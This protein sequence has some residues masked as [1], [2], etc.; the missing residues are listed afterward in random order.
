MDHLDPAETRANATWK[1]AVVYQVYPWTFAEDSQRSPQLGH[2]SIKGI[3]ERLPYLES[4]GVNALWLSPFYPSPMVDG[5]YDVADFKN[6]HPLLGTLD[7][8]DSLIRVAHEKHIRLMV[9]FVANHT[10]DQHEWF[11]KSRRREG[12]YDDWY[13]WRPGTV[14]EHGNRRPPNNWASVFSIPQRKARER[15]EMSWL[16]PEE[17]TPPVSAWKWDEVREEFY[18]HSFAV[19]QP[20]LNWS[21]SQVREA[22]K[23]IMRFWL[24]RGVDG[25]R[26]DAINHVGKNMELHDEGVNTAYNE[27][28]YENPYDQLL[29]HNSCNYPRTLHDYIWQMCQVLKEEQYKD[30]DLRAVLEAYM[31]ESELR[32]MDAIA[33][34][35][36]STFNF[37]GLLASWDAGNRKI[38]MD[39]YYERLQRDAVANQVN[40]NHDKPRLASRLG[41]NGA[42]A[43]AVLNL[44]LPGMRFVYSGEEL[45]LVDA[46]VPAWRMQDP[47]GLRD[48]ERTPIPW[49]D[50]LPNAGFST[51]EPGDLWLPTNAA[52]EHK[53]V[54]RQKQQ[55]TSSLAL[56]KAA[57]RLCNELPATVSGGY[58]PLH[59]DHDQV[60]AYGREDEETGDQVVVLV[61]FA[62]D[63]QGSVRVTDSRFVIGEV[64][65]SSLHVEETNRRVDL[66]AGV[67]L[68]ADEAVVIKKL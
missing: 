36:A 38:Q 4:L 64:I 21:N 37:G 10:S 3:E 12:G 61:N 40:G 7:D 44:F 51:A 23:D 15:G 60:L 22:M 66:R 2:G 47:N 65:L 41:D 50:T 32:D 24:D 59:T 33:P 19:E 13:I 49:D 6:V 26:I 9:D 45:G 55:S 25:F 39:Y 5:G 35:V 58:V 28:W 31:G 68:E 54:M 1:N 18:M 63:K 20:D 16:R 14:D 34:E 57:L 42:R 8:I 43:A 30:R 29:R 27:E 53:A 17:W 67:A 46:D 48:P 62:R 56:Y 11:Q 52:D